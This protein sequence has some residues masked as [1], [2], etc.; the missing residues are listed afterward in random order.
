MSSRM[1]NTWQ[2]A[3]RMSHIKG[4]LLTLKDRDKRIHFSH[5]Y[6]YQLISAAL[7]WAKHD[8]AIARLLKKD[9]GGM[10]LIHP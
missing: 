7:P 1:G 9:A 4:T 10:E 5:P 2:D 6:S 8:L 3:E